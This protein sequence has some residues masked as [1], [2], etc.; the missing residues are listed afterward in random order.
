[1]HRIIHRV[2]RP[3]I[4]VVLFSVIASGSIH[5]AQSTADVPAS[6][7]LKKTVRSEILG[8]KTK[9]IVSE[10]DTLSVTATC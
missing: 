1:M 10:D 2:I 8:E 3:M 7:T 5:A 9:S 6:N 4:L